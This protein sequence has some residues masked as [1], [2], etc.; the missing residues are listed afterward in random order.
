[1]TDSGKAPPSLRERQG[2]RV[3]DELRSAFIGLALERGIQGF[4][5][6][7]VAIEAGVSDRTLYRYYPSRE[8]IIEAVQQH[9]FEVIEDA[10]RRRG[11]ESGQAADWGHPEFVAGA[12]EVFEEHADVVRVS[13]LIRQAGLGDT[14][15]QERN[16][17]IREGIGRF[18][19]HPDA[20]DA[21]GAIVRLLT[22]SE[23]W[24]RLT[25]AD[26]GL[27]SREA[28]L[29]AHW[30]A[31]VLVAA[32]SEQGGPLRPVVDGSAEGDGHRGVDRGG[33]G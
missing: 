28:G 8:A 16:D 20:A 12:F 9:A 19:I 15:H 4:S 5:L 14:R 29:A 32:A 18:G 23:G 31:Q 1:M 25:S 6:H 22:S 30:A 7:D 10:K 17:D 21:L 2:R 3:R 13:A 24:A 11:V 26:V 27:E 33:L